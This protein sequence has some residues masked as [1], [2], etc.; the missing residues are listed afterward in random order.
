MIIIVVTKPYKGV[1]SFIF[2]VS[3]FSLLFNHLLPLTELIL[4]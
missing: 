1:K 3:G 2:C 4:H